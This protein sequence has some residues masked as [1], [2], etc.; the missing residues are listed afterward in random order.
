MEY[1]NEEILEARWEDERRKH[2]TLETGIYVEDELI[3]FS[4]IILSDTK[5][6]LYLPEQF[7][8]VP[9]AVIEG[10][11][12]YI[13]SSGLTK[14]LL[15]DQITMDEAEEIFQN[16]V[17]AGAMNRKADELEILMGVDYLKRTDNYER[18]LSDIGER[19]WNNPSK[20]N[21]LAIVWENSL[22]DVQGE[23]DNEN[24]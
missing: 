6:L 13:F 9:E 24:P 20:I 5:I 12:E 21:E 22:D 10:N 7:I 23:P 19:I 18:I 11:G 16:D 4:Q 15:K 2:T 3:T 8:P 1:Y 14:Y 17:D